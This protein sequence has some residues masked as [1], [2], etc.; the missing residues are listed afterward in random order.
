MN[1]LQETGWWIRKDISIALFVDADKSAF[2][3]TTQIN[4]LLATTIISVL[5]LCIAVILLI[6]QQLKYRRH[7]RQSGQPAA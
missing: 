3:Q 7:L 2:S 4:G 5:L 6:I 1:D